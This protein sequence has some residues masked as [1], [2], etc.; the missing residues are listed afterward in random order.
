MKQ[1]PLPYRSIY[2]RR[3]RLFNLIRPMLE[4]CRIGWLSRPSLNGLDLQLERLLPRRGGWYV[5]AGAY[6]GFQQSNTYYFA[7][8]KGWRGVLVEPL[9]PLAQR[10]K[11]RRRESNVVCCALGAPENAGSTVKLRHAG[12]MTMVR[13]A[14]ADDATEHARASSGLQGQ[15]LPPLEQF[16]EAP[17]RTLTDVLVE[18]GT[19]W[20]F[21]LLSLDVEGFEADALRGL[22]L[23]RFVPRA[24]CVEVRHENF[25]AVMKMLEEHYEKPIMLTTNASYAD[26]FFAVKDHGR[27]AAA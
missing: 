17:V 13:G 5:E 7:K 8:M 25:T 20:D 16:V 2:S 15:G 19:P 26:C 11:K 10:C 4:W 14:L 24:I 9:P 3:D 21:D 18:T 6:D 27:P 1:E 22:D 23:S 12:L